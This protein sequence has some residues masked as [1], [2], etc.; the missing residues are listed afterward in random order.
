M[1]ERTGSD[2]RIGA[3]LRGLLDRLDQLAHGDVLARLDDREATALDLGR[4][5]DRLAAAGLDDRLERPRLV[6]VLEAEQLRRA[7]DLATVEGGDLQPFQAL[8]RHFAK[9]LRAVVLDHQPEQ[10]LDVDVGLVRRYSDRC[11][12]L[13]HARAKLGV[14]DQLEVG[15][16]QIQRADVADRHQRLGAGSGAVGQ[17]PRVQVQV[18]VGLGL[19]DVAGAAAGDRLELVE[20]QAEHRGQR[21]RRGVEL[22]RRQ[23]R[24][25]ALVVGDLRGHQA[26]EPPLLPPAR[27]GSMRLAAAWS[28]SAS[29]TCSIRASA[30]S[31]CTIPSAPCRSC[32]RTSSWSFRASSTFSATWGGKGGGTLPF[33]ARLI[34]NFVCLIAETI[35]WV[36]GTSS[37]SRSHPVVSADL[38]N[39]FACFAPMSRSMPSLTD[40]APSFAIAS[41][42]STPFGQRSLQK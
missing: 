40:S 26:S 29:T 21:L 27:W 34:A 41:R 7:Q 10:V 6:R 4:I 15:L 22:L 2:H 36:F 9:P 35:P 23:R 42:G 20:L 31:P 16:P 39:H 37:V 14:V 3:C 12:V 8:V 32:P 25:T 13:V 30:R 38:T 28:G 5:V 19:V 24:E 18:V 1:A 11:E 33:L 17:D